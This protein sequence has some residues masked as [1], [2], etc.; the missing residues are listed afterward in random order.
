MKRRNFVKGLVG[1][2]VVGATGIAAARELR[3]P[4]FFDISLVKNSDPTQVDILPE[5]PPCKNFADRPILMGSMTTALMPL[6]KEDQPQNLHW[7]M[8]GDLWFDVIV[9]W[10][11]GEQKNLLRAFNMSYA[12]SKERDRVM[13]LLKAAQRQIGRDVDT[14]EEKWGQWVRETCL[15][16][17]EKVP[18]QFVPPKTPPSTDFFGYR[19][20]GHFIGEA[21]DSIPRNPTASV[22][23]LPAQEWLSRK[24]TGRSYPDTDTEPYYEVVPPRDLPDGFRLAKDIGHITSPRFNADNIQFEEDIA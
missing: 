2:G 19:R 16:S 17:R 22:P 3:D 9:Y 14:L 12:L 18:L 24:H 4:Q 1:T 13:E 8:T 20:S 5:S 21:G 11:N 6:V 23:V 10:P 15:P 7:A